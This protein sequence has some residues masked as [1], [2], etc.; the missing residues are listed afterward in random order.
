MTATLKTSLG[1][2]GAF[3]DDSHGDDNLYDMMVALAEGPNALTAHQATVAAAVLTG[4]VA[5]KAFKLKS[6]SVA[7]AV[8]GTA[9][10]TIVEIN[11]NGTAVGS[12]TIA[13]DDADGTVSHVDLDVD[14]AVGDTL[15]IEVDTA[16]TAGSGLNVTATLSPLV[17][18]A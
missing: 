4:M 3:V 7:L 6:F 11:H 18:Q 8:C 2:A 13:H 14:V 5:Y 12:V 17:L 15:E 1:E 16:P 10:S 9:G